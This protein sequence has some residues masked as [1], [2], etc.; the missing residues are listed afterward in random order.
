MSKPPNLADRVAEL[1][2]QQ[3]DLGAPAI[4]QDRPGVF[5]T[6]VDLLSR[7]NYAIAG[8]AEELAKDRS[9]TGGVTRAMAEIFSGI[10]PI[11][12]EKR[13][14]PEVLENLGVGTKTLADAFPALEGTWVGQFGSRGAAGLA[15]DIVTDPLTYLTGGAARGALKVLTKSGEV[16]LNAKGAAKFNKILHSNRVDRIIERIGKRADPFML[17][18]TGV[19][20]KRAEIAEKLFAKEFGG[21]IPDELLDS[22]GLK[23]MGK[24]II[25][26]DTISK[27]NSN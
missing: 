11:Q 20:T 19:V 18:E 26:G 27:A 16:A 12:G 1:E 7:P 5:R 8:F 10:G 13:A 3:A 24:T 15:L 17:G 14:F 22:G 4:E 25:R 9:V 6:I 23:W 21:K 2:A